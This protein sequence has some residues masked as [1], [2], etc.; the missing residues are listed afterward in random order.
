M[1]ASSIWNGCMT[2]GRTL[3]AE[4][5]RV[6]VLKKN[7]VSRQDW[8]RKRPIKIKM[9]TTLHTIC[10]I[11]DLECRKLGNVRKENLPFAGERSLGLAAAVP[12]LERLHFS[13]SNKFCTHILNNKPAKFFAF[14]NSQIFHTC[15][16]VA[17]SEVLHLPPLSKNRFR[18]TAFL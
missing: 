12:N 1:Q 17:H 7:F 10:C 8:V 9:S 6:L 18:Q 11:T 4:T 5:C 13:S 14:R 16:L 2:W 15:S 3:C